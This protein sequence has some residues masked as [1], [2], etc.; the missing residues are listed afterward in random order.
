MSW[1]AVSCKHKNAPLLE[2]KCPIYV[3]NLPVKFYVASW[4]PLNMCLLFLHR[5]HS[6]L[7][8]VFLVFF[9][10]LSSVLAGSHQALLQFH[11]GSRDCLPTSH[12]S[13]G[14]LGPL[15]LDTAIAGRFRSSYPDCK[16]LGGYAEVKNILLYC[17]SLPASYVH[18]PPCLPH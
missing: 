4:D 8:L 6:Y 10:K 12:D 9:L 13:A 3:F 5:K 17:A 14:C 1:T 15:W 18:T 11:A 2:F 7:E 16:I